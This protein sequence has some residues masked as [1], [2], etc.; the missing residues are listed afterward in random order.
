MPIGLSIYFSPEYLHIIDST[1]VVMDNSSFS[2]KMQKT[3]MPNKS[4]IQVKMFNFMFNSTSS[5]DGKEG[6]WLSAMKSLEMEVWVLILEGDENGDRAFNDGFIKL[7]MKDHFLTFSL[8][9]RHI[10]NTLPLD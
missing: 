3:S 8:L 6:T 9:H 10:Y 5:W 7:E 2:F 1:K 4:I